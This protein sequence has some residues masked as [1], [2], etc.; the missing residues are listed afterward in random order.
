MKFNISY[1]FNRTCEAREPEEERKAR[2]EN[3]NSSK[4]L[5]LLDNKLTLE[6]VVIYFFCGLIGFLA[7]LS[8]SF[9]LFLIAKHEFL[10]TETNLC[11]AGLACSDLL[12]GLLTIPLVVSCS[13]KYRFAVCLAMELT[14]RFIAVSTILHLLIVACER[15]LRICKPLSFQTT[16][17]TGRVLGFL[18]GVWCIS[19]AMSLVQLTWII[20]AQKK[21]TSHELDRTEIIY[22]LVWFLVFVLVPLL[23]II[24]LYC[25]ILI[26]L[27]KQ[28]KNISKQFEQVK[29][30][31][32]FSKT[33]RER[34]ATFVYGAMLIIFAVVWFSYIFTALEEDFGN[35]FV[36]P[37]ELVTF[38]AILRYSASVINP[39]LYTFLKEDFKKAIRKTFY[40]DIGGRSNTSNNQ[41]SRILN[42]SATTRL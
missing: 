28:L 38:L 20:P 37:T 29:R 5:E 9:V 31:Q 39:V 22:D 26:V 3:W 11:L 8:N 1:C 14:Q 25:R 15:Y 36:I 21:A 2:M 7:I 17:I 32:H 33:K 10:R 4:S 16:H 23:T 27:K 24:V 12:A 41:S 13:V 19:L 30:K 6:F 18:A 34:R 40:R 42:G 35:K